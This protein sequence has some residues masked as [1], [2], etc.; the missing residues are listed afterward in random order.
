MQE[1]GSMDSGRTPYCLMY[2]EGLFLNHIVKH[3]KFD[4]SR[5]SKYEL[6]DYE[7]AVK[8]LQKWEEV[9]LFMTE[10]RWF[11]T[12][13]R[14]VTSM[15]RNA[16]SEAEAYEMGYPEFEEEINEKYQKLLKQL[17]PFPE[18][19]EKVSHEL[20]RSI[21]E[22]MFMYRNPEEEPETSPFVEIDKQRFFK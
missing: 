6:E 14:E 3:W 5:L 4:I 8:K 2:E 1:R 16:H 18:W 13:I 11:V 9:R 12:E 19:K 22:S 10:V 15:R 21:F 17:E 20:D 7:C